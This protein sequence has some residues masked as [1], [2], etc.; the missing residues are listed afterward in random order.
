MSVRSFIFCEKRILKVD[1]TVL[2][3]NNLDIKITDFGLA[4]SLV[5]K[6]KQVNPQ[7]SVLEP[8]HSSSNENEEPTGEEDSMSSE[9]PEVSGEES[10]DVGDL[11]RIRRRTLCGTAGFR[12]PEQV[13]ERYVDYYL[14]SGYD[15]KVRALVPRSLICYLLSAND[16]ATFYT[17]RQTISHSE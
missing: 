17:R 14:R 16:S 15:E 1:Y 8:T 3:F 4:G 7:E 6:K 2:L 13:G 11:R 10:G 12:P 9:E 5:E